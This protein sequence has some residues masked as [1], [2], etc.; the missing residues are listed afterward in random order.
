MSAHN[1]GRPDR[2]DLPV[3]CNVLKPEQHRCCIQFL[4]CIV[5]EPRLMAPVPCSPAIDQAVTLTFGS[6]IQALWLLL[7]RRPGAEL[8][9]VVWV[10]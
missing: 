9:M 8:P 5:E 7:S 2:I 1:Q 10:E 4:S 3:G 6:L